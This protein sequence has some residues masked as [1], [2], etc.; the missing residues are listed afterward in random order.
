MLIDPSWYPEFTHT[1][2]EHCEGFSMPCENVDA[3]WCSSHTYY[4]N[5]RQN[6]HYLCDSCEKEMVD[7]W[8]D[9]WQD[10]IGGI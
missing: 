1:P 8:N 6:W 5:E 4:P 3:H 9:Q 2:L 7:F 10:A